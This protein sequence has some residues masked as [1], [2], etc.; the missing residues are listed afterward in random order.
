MQGRGRLGY[1]DPPFFPHFTDSVILWVSL[2]HGGF[3]AWSE[4]VRTVVSDVRS[5]PSN[6]ELKV[7]VSHAN[8][9]R[10]QT[11]TRIH[12]R[13]TIS[14]GP[15]YRRHW[16]RDVIH[17]FI[18]RTITLQRYGVK[19]VCGSAVWSRPP[20]E[21]RWSPR[22]N[23]STIRCFTADLDDHLYFPSR[24]RPRGS[25]AET[26]REAPPDILNDHAVS[27]TNRAVRPEAWRRD[28]SQYDSIYRYVDRLVFSRWGP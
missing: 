14:K 4:G 26:Q 15:G 2:S 20:A 5:R 7:L 17:D 16:F 28:V 24:V 6:N 3:Q 18:C 11:M 25:G 1:H 13:C 10:R 12:P 8:S 27:G 21:P 23:P 9:D 19:W 22:R